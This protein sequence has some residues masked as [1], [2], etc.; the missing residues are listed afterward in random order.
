MDSKNDLIKK[1]ATVRIKEKLLEV[2]EVFQSHKSV[3]LSMVDDILYDDN[4]YFNVDHS[5][6][7]IVTQTG[8]N[9]FKL[10][11]TAIYTGIIT[12]YAPLKTSNVNMVHLKYHESCELSFDNK[13]KITN[14]YF[15][16]SRNKNGNLE[17]LKI[18][19]SNKFEILKLNWQVW[20]KMS[21]TKNVIVNNKFNYHGL[22]I[23][24]VMLLLKLHFNMNESVSE[25]VPEL[26]TPSAYNFNTDEFQDRLE[27]VNMML[28]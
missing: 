24:D 19:L 23:K 28:D 22:P 2:S 14:I 20:N 9:S 10:T 6:I 15:K 5:R 11:T 26:K 12:Q 1:E 3:L 21:G 13:Q 8:L 16:I 18:N 4:E 7:N 25:L 17:T 27:V